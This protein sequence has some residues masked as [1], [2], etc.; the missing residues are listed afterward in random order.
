LLSSLRV[1]RL[2]DEHYSLLETRFI[3]HSQRATVQSIC[4]TYNRLVDEGQSPLILMPRTIL[5][6]EI[7]G[8]MLNQIGT[9]IHSLTAVDTL[10][11]I[12]DRQLMKKV[13]QAYD[14]S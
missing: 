13:Q 14:K 9:H 7:N 5:R 1:G 6:D 8:A 3:T 11:T 2:I 10:D 4:H 12:V